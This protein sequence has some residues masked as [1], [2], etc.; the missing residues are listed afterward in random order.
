M[1]LILTRFL[2]MI[3]LKHFAQGGTCSHTAVLLLRGVD[4]LSRS[5]STLGTGAILLINLHA[6]ILFF[7]RLI[8]DSW[9]KKK[10]DRIVATGLH[11]SILSA[12][13]YRLIEPEKRLT[14]FFSV[15]F[16][17]IFFCSHIKLSTFFNM[18]QRPTNRTRMSRTREP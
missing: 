9:R 11:F 12:R 15:S 10:S 16:F 3:D 4:S 5:K 8:H 13:P 1:V 17:T 18:F 7:S 14:I 2:G 6:F